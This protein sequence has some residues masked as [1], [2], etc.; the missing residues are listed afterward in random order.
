MSDH[1]NCLC[2][3]NHPDESGICT[4]EAT[5][6]LRFSNFPNDSPLAH[7]KFWD[8]AM[9]DPCRS[10]TLLAKGEKAESGA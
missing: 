4:M 8:V 10:A 1:C 5:G 7:L 6:A 3:I 9:C 2:A